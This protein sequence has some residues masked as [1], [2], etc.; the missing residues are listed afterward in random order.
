MVHVAYRRR[1]DSPPR[2]SAYRVLALKAAGRGYESV[3]ATRHMLP[4]KS[5]PILW[6][7]ILNRVAGLGRLQAAQ[8]SFSFPSLAQVLL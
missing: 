1:A 8:P 3:E 2:D 4:E 7:Q 6:A 5:A